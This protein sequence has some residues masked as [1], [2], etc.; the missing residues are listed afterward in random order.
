MTEGL[1]VQQQPNAL[2]SNG[3]SPR[4]GLTPGPAQPGFVWGGA[5]GTEGI[6]PGADASVL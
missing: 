3:G 4:S 5:M 1:T 2:G 6:S